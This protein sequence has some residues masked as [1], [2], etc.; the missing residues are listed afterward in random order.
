MDVDKTK[1][2]KMKMF[3]FFFYKKKLRR[4]TFQLSH[5]II[6]CLLCDINIRTI[7]FIY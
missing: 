7:Y 5:A 4:L 1:R 2:D 3:L 6:L